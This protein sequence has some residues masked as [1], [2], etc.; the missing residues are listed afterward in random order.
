MAANFM[1]TGVVR[2]NPTDI[3]AGDYIAS[4]SDPGTGQG[5]CAPLRSIFC[6]T[7]LNSSL[8]VE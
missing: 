7:G 5:I 3:K 8:T 1:V 2:R 4:T 6:R